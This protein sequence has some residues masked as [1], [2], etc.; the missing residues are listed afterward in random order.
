VLAFEKQ[1]ARQP[2]PIRIVMIKFSTK[3]IINGQAE[4]ED[5]R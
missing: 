3:S 5:D 2:K 1:S 4:A